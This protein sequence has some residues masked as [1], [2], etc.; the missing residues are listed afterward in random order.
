[1][2]H[3]MGYTYSED[4]A[5]CDLIIMNT[6]CVRENAE[7]KVFGHLGALKHLKKE[8]PD[9]VVALC[10]CMMQQEEIVKEIK[11]KYR[12][13]GLLFGTH[14]LYKF[15]ELLY[16]SLHSEKSVYE[17]LDLDGQL[18]E[19]L[20]VARK[21]GYKAWVTIMY[22]C[23]NFCSYC[24][25]PYVRGRE[26]SRDIL[27]IVEEIEMLAKEGVKEITLL[28]Q[29][30]NS[31]GKDLSF[32]VSFANLLHRVHEIEGILRIRFMTPH[33]KDL[34]DELILAIQEL[35]KVCKH[36]HFAGSSRKH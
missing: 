6:C 1:M 7:Q 4:L 22:G 32:E 23:N 16:Q 34:S 10:G 19:G 12:H 36:V 33:P 26:R 2:I 31:Y 21:G 13:V 20:P 11:K 3:D 9:L 30:V 35:P 8:N 25:V 17:I 28:G 18:A 24:I 5:L 27:A 15:P 29:N 14:N